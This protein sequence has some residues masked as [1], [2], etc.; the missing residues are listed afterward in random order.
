MS[1]KNRSRSIKSLFLVLI[2]LSVTAFLTFIAVN[3][4]R[5]EQGFSDIGTVAVVVAMALLSVLM[6]R[7]AYQTMTG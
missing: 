7:S 2:Y 4:Y 5:Y 3:I 6:L 1:I